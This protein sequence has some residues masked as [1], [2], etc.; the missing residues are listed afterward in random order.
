[1]RPLFRQNLLENL[2]ALADRIVVLLWLTRGSEPRATEA[3]C[4]SA[5]P[6]IAWFPFPLSLVP[7][8]S[9]PSSFFK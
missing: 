9:K 6:I 3:P 8:F 2:S 5:E 4:G 1:M 7:E